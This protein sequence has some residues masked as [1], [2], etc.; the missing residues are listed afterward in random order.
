M[1]PA[2]L[3]YVLVA[4]FV[5]RTCQLFSRICTRVSAVRPSDP[6]LHD[7]LAR[8]NLVYILKQDARLFP[9]SPHRWH[10]REMIVEI[11]VCIA[12]WFVIA[13]VYRR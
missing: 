10:R 4:I 1:R 8:N 6:K 5:L 3:L 11:I 12:L 7:L 9:G 13:V 2:D